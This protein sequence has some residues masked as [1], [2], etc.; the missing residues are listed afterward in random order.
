[1]ESEEIVRNVYQIGIHTKR[2]IVKLVENRI[3]LIVPNAVLQWPLEMV[4][5]VS[6][7]GV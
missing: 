6:S 1:M 2:L 7:W 5:M 3:T 4:N